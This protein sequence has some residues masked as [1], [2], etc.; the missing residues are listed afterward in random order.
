MSSFINLFGGSM[1]PL[2]DFFFT[3]LQS[4]DCPTCRTLKILLSSSQVYLSRFL[5]SFSLLLASSIIFNLP[6]IMSPSPS[7]L[8]SFFFQKPQLSWIYQVQ[9]FYSA[10]VNFFSCFFQ[11]LDLNLDIGLDLKG[12]LSVIAWFWGSFC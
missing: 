8:D 10:Q 9:V 4:Y 11:I 7:M 12:C 3:F 6:S 1:I 5:F 2:C